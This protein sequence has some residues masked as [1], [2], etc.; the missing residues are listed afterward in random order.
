MRMRVR[1]AQ[2]GK[3]PVLPWAV[4]PVLLLFWHKPGATAP[5]EPPYAAGMA[6]KRQKKKKKK[7]KTGKSHLSWE[8]YR[9]LERMYCCYTPFLLLSYT[10]HHALDISIQWHSSAP[11][12]RAGGLAQAENLPPENIPF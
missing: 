6:L 12:Q 2:W 10:S 5:T 7:K 8:P 11:S 1:L 9:F 4:D 3:D